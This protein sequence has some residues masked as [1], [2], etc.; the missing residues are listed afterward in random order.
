MIKQLNSNFFRIRYLIDNAEHLIKCTEL[1][2]DVDQL[3]DVPITPS[4]A[5]VDVLST[6][7][8]PS[9][10]V[11]YAPYTVQPASFPVVDV[12]ATAPVPSSPVVDA[13]ST[14]QVPSSQS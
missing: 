7:Q 14:A 2:T 5:Q 12:L 8:V 11:I 4:T 3:P 1:H 13:P 10:P 6:G 9:S